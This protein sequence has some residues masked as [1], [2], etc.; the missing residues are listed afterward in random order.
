M[1]RRKA[2]VKLFFF[3]WIGV[4]FMA[5]LLSTLTGCSTV[6]DKVVFQPPE[7]K[8]VTVEKIVPVQCLNKADLPSFPSLKTESEYLEL[9]DYSFVSMLY[10]ERQLL[11]NYSNILTAAIAPCL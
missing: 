2:N 3:A 1:N 10:I 4:I 9:D 8:V 6:P 5:I 11:L 7:T